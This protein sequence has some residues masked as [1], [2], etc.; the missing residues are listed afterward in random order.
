[1]KSF[2]RRIEDLEKIF[3]SRSDKFLKMLYAV[4]NDEYSEFGDRE[5]LYP[6]FP[7]LD[8]LRK[9]YA[10]QGY[11]IIDI[12]VFKIPGTFVAPWHGDKCV[13]KDNQK[14]KRVLITIIHPCEIEQGQWF[15]NKEEIARL[16]EMYDNL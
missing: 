15:D 13:P 16:K 6:S 5:R 9:H 8:E 2:I 1:M 7:S 10:D 14:G 4:H 11:K 3:R 12:F